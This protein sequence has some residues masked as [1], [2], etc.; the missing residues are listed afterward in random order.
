MS[1]PLAETD[2]QG[3]IYYLRNGLTGRSVSSSV[4]F[5][6]VLCFFASLTGGVVYYLQN[7]QSAP[8]LSLDFL[9]EGDQFYR[10]GNFS[11][12]IKEYEAALAIAPAN[13]Q[14]LVNLG[15]AAY[16]T[17]DKDRAVS[18]F[19]QALRFKSDEPDASYFL[20]LLYL[21]RGELDAAIEM[22]SLSA[23]VRSGVAAAQAYSD[24][25]VAYSRRG[26]LKPAAES[27]QRALDI[28]PGFEPAR[29][30]LESIQRRMRQ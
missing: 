5:L 16:A 11:S 18:A 17:G 9:A 20:G 19:Q 3:F 4:F 15:A 28:E 1:E 22:L 7:Y 14:S 24:L 6:T 30:N 2:S 26:D 12:A 27:Y 29:R 8:R 25:G 21:E 10:D 23:R 13:P